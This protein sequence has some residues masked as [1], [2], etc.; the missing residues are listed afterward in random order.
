M[1]QPMEVNT[2]QPREGIDGSP[3][4]A[5]DGKMKV[6]QPNNLLG[7]FVILRYLYLILSEFS[8]FSAYNKICVINQCE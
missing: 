5:S 2:L 6:S 4:E 1:M 7:N 3:E 8:Y